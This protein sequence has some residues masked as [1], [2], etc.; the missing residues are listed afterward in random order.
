MPSD[1]IDRLKR[2]VAGLFSWASR[3]H[4]RARLAGRESPRRFDDIRVVGPLARRNGI[5][6]GA[7]LQDAALRRHGIASE[8]LDAAP[9]LRDP[10][11]RLPHRPGGAY[12]FHSGGPQA[13]N[14]I[15]GTLPGAAA[16][17]RVG[18]WAWELPT[19]PKDWPRPRGLVSEIWTP[20]RFSKDGLAPICDVPIHVVPHVVPPRP[21]R[22]PGVQGRFTVLAM[23]DSRSSFDRKNPMGAIQ[24]FRE[25]FGDSPDHRLILK[26]T[27]QPR[28]IARLE[29]ELDGTPSRHRNIE[30]L[31]DYLDDDG[32]DRLYRSADAMLSLHRAE[33]FGLPM[34]EAMARGVPVVATGWSG[35]MEFTS[36]TNCVLVPFR[37]VPVRDTLWYQGYGDSEWAE[38]DVTAA[39][40]GLS[41]L[42]AD[43]A[44]WQSIARA[45]WETVGR[46]NA[47]WS[48]P[49]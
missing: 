18:Y 13:A 9:A 31:T 14:L 26:L 20:S 37:I 47:E 24:A 36:A 46:L 16:A 21:M 8:L 23:A 48:L 28:S 3:L 32:L 40:A 22:P 17:Y 15:L 19:P 42:A 41:R 34:L 12:V 44:H 10:M 1:A 38:P 45:G 39:A 27:G 7:I 29:S 30:I 49:A 4:A 43:P 35:N 11:F 6:S 2:P 5:S 25:A 33:G